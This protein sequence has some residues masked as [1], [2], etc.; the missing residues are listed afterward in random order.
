MLYADGFALLERGDFVKALDAF[1]REAAS[2]PLVANAVDFTDPLGVAASAFRN[3]DIDAA[4]RYVRVGID[5]DPTRPD[6]HRLLG[7]VLLA[8]RRDDEG[9]ME[10]RLAVRLGPDDER[11]HLALADALV[12]LRR[13]ADAEDAFRD[14]LR[15]LP[16]SGRAHYR[17]GRLYQRQNKTLDALGEFEAAARMHP[18]IGASR[19]LQTIG[20]L[21]AA[22]QDF[23]AALQAYQLASTSIRTTRMRIARSV[24]RTRGW[25]AATKRSQ[26]S[27]WRC[28]WLPIRPTSTSR[29]RSL[30]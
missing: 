2:D 22:K 20:A 10:L 28:G 6:A 5:R 18:L 15:T 21:N 1:R 8:S 4:A 25:N 27:P 13:F 19:L 12:Q 3:G 17:L 23:D 26:N 16:L 29:C 24:L 11:A 9:L 7:R 14:A 30:I